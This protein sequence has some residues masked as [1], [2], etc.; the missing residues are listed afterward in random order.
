[1]LDA[2]LSAISA[3]GDYTRGLIAG[4]P[5]E[6]MGGRELLRALG[7]AGEEDTTGNFLA[8][9]A[10]DIATDPLTYAGSALGALAGARGARYARGLIPAEIPQGKATGNLTNALGGAAKF[11]A[12]LRDVVVLTKP[13][14]LWS[15]YSTRD[16]LIERFIEN[17]GERS[18]VSATPATL[19]G[20]HHPAIGGVMSGRTARTVGGEEAAN[21]LASLAE[22]GPSQQQL[23]RMAGGYYQHDRVVLAPDSSPATQRHER[24]HAIID[25]ASK[26]V[27]ETDQLPLLMRIPAT[28]KAEGNPGWL[29]DAGVVIDELAAQTLEQRDLRGKL[30]GATRFLFQPEHNA[31]YSGNYARRELSPLVQAI[32]G[33]L[34]RGMIHAGGAAGGMAGGLFA[35][36]PSTILG[37]RFGNPVPAMEEP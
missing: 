11:K 34:P 12:P 23:N 25:G 35:S 13:Q 37:G 1:M 21:R 8:G 26:G 17:A 22:H 14:S 36:L 24:V 5:G 4:Q 19:S 3:P 16:E 10:T 28:L 2:I 30:L 6:R 31:Y 9:M 29:R 7:L 20:P 27:G 33:Y 15:P 18:V 32:Y